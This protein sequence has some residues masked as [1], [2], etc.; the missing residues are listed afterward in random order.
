[1]DFTHGCHVTSDKSWAE[2]QR[3]KD[4]KDA[5]ER[6]KRERVII[7]TTKRKKAIG[8]KRWSR[9][10]DQHEIR[11][12]RWKMK[13]AALGKGK[14]CPPKPRRRLKADVIGGQSSSFELSE[15]KDNWLDMEPATSRSSSEGG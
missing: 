1:M 8:D 14:D 15:D 12:Q 13:C 6:E 11:L 2:L 7:Q 5:K 10:K 9:A 3:L 4:E